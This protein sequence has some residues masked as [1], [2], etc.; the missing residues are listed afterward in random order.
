MSE[1]GSDRPFA[2]TVRFDAVGVVL[3][4]RGELLRLDHLEGAW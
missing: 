3:N 4:A 1:R 2:R